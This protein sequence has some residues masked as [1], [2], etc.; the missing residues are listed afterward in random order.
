MAKSK[1]HKSNQHGKCDNKK[2]RADDTI[3]MPEALEAP[4][5]RIDNSVK[6]LATLP[7]HYLQATDV[8][9]QLIEKIGEGSQGQVYSMK[10]RDQPERMAAVKLLPFCGDAENEIEVLGRL[11][12][13]DN[14]MMALFTCSNAR[15][16][17]IVFDLCDC[18]LF[19]YSQKHRIADND[20]PLG[21][22]AVTMQILAGVEHMHSHDIVHCDLK[23]ENIF[24]AN[25]VIKIGDFGMS[26]V[27]KPG[28]ICST[29]AGSGLY[30][31]PEILCARDNIYSYDGR[32]ADIWS[33]GVC[34]FTMKIGLF[35]FTET[36]LKKIY[37]EHVCVASRKALQRNQIRGAW[38]KVVDSAFSLDAKC[39]PCISE[40]IDSTDR[41][42]HR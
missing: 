26:Q 2:V 22:K 4:E 39:R 8:N 38:L 34:I 40:L 15:S 24:L 5:P 25:G 29:P 3:F 14:I 35:P 7:D 31:A 13:H 42:E 10:K 9:W 19:D 11:T 18:D 37:Y 27:M 6:S 16:A 17:N 41:I 36:H 32:A 30:R 1:R 23:L 33:I 20:Q 28:Q 12:A 21:L